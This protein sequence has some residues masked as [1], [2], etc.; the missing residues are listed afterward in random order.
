MKNYLIEVEGI[1]KCGK[2]LI[3]KYIYTLSN[4]RYIV[5]V[6]GLLSSMVYSEKFNRDYD[7]EIVYKPIILYLDVNEEDRLVRCKLT[8]EPKID[9]DLDRSLFEKYL[10]QLTQ[11]GFIIYRY[12]TSEMTPYQIAKDVINKLESLN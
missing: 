1:D 10:N 8:K 3:E 7:Y 5:H 9:A 11:E 6:R 4:N 2:D 12:N